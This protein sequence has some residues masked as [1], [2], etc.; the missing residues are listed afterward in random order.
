MLSFLGAS[1]KSYALVVLQYHHV[2]DKTPRS[3]SISPEL[4]KAH[5]AYIEKRQFRVLDILT[6]K[7]ILQ[8]GE[9]LP[10]ASVVITFDDGYKSVYKHAFL[11]LKKRAWPFAVFINTKSHDE[12]NPHFM[13]W[14]ELK[15]LQDAGAVI[16]N[17]TDSHPYLIRRRSGEAFK[18][19]QKRRA[20]EIEFAEQRIKKKLGKS[21]KLFAYPFGEFDQSLK[22]YLKENAYLAFGQQSGPIAS[23]SDLQNIPRFPF[24][25]AYGQLDDF[26]T[27]L[28]SLPFPQA[29]VKVTTENGKVLSDPELPAGIGRPVLRIASP[30]MNYIGETA[31]YASGQGKINTDV[32]GGVLVAQAKTDLPS[33]RS[34]YNCTARAGGERYYWYSQLFIRRKANGRWYSE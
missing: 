13:S 5:M 8:K 31:C 4:F 9:A 29:R 24:G 6:L 26:S 20:L 33:G 10:D 15:E 23:N 17:H 21:H 22:S 18:Q 34:R 14:E 30:L 11:E 25:G 7:R 16:G 1:S 3:T 27:K 32:K 2:S 19:W 12:K 28:L